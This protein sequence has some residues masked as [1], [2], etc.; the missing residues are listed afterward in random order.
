MLLLLVAD[1]GEKGVIEKSVHQ[2]Y[3]VEWE[4]ERKW[5]RGK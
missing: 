5:V 1:S 4:E 2:N 3:D